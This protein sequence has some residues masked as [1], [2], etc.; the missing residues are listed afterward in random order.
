MQTS[1]SYEPVMLKMQTGISKLGD[2][3]YF[4]WSYE[5]EM[6]LKVKD[7][8]KNCIY[9]TVEEY[10]NRTVSVKIES[11]S[12]TTTTTTTT[13][14][15]LSR[16]KIEKYLD[17]DSKCLA[18]IGLHVSEKY[19]GKIKQ[20]KNAKE[21]WDSLKEESGA[22]NM[23]YILSLKF[24][25]HT[26]S[27]GEKETLLKF[28][29]KVT[30]ICD[31]LR[32]LGVDT[33]ENE[34]CYKILSHLPDQ[35]KSIALTCCGQS[36]LSVAFLRQQFMMIE[37]SSTSSHTTKKSSEATTLNTNT[38]QHNPEKRSCYSCGTPGH[39]ASECRAPQWKKEKYAKEKAKHQNGDD[40]WKKDRKEKGDKKEEK[41]KEAEIA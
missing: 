26:C 23:Y 10:E 35:Y 18:L 32:E 6:Y 11:E 41:G 19:Y 20:A 4:K 40:K 39:L 25:F 15:G 37:K 2:D 14:S 29:D 36:N 22:T 12:M 16:E 34:V 38:K 8:W 27:F 24:Q 21:A 9:A 31:K 3:N 1:S 17:D 30:M 33:E 5:M 13:K 28:V 7:L